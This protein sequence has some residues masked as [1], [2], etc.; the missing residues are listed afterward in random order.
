MTVLGEPIVFAGDRSKLG[1]GGRL[2]AATMIA[3]TAIYNLLVE[4]WQ[5]EAKSFNFF[6]GRS[7]PCFTPLGVWIA[8]G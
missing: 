2:L 8:P 3:I 5:N 4:R 1:Y 7:R 6:K